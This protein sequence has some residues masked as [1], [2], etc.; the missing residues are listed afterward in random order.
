MPHILVQAGEWREHMVQ[1][2]HEVIAHLGQPPIST[3][4]RP[5]RRFKWVAATLVS[6]AKHFMALFIG[7]VGTHNMYAP[8]AKAA[9]HALTLEAGAQDAVG[10]RHIFAAR[11]LCEWGSHANSCSWQ[12]FTSRRP[13]LATCSVKIF[14]TNP[15]ECFGFDIFYLARIISQCWR[16]C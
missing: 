7:L 1:I 11:V 4:K 10:R 15:L 16:P 5:F 8:L 12:C 14:K 13:N 9:R 2:L 3:K 6:L